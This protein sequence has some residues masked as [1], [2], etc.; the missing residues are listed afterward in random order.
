MLPNTF[1]IIVFIFIVH[2]NQRHHLSCSFSKENSFSVHGYVF[3]RH[4]VKLNQ[5]GYYHDN[6]HTCSWFICM[7]L[8]YLEFTLKEIKEEYYYPTKE[9]LATKCPEL[10]SVGKGPGVTK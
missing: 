5:Y 1:N 10:E 2:S 7:H 3:I 9:N 4:K 8:Y 6:I